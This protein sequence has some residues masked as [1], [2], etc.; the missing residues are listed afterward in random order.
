MFVPPLKELVSR[1]AVVV[2]FGCL[3]PISFVLAFAQ[4]IWQLVLHKLGLLHV[5]QRPI[6]QADS[7]CVLWDKCLS[8]ILY[9]AFFTNSGIISILCARQ[10]ALRHQKIP[11]FFYSLLLHYS[12]RFVLSTRQLHL[13]RSIRLVLKRFRHLLRN[14]LEQFRKHSL[15]KSMAGSRAPLKWRIC[16]LTPA[17]RKLIKMSS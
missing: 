13:P 14:T 2:L 6:P 16:G 4:A 10:E 3:F 1:L 17:E 11:I 12:F 15:K 7:R 5:Y 8:L 9:S